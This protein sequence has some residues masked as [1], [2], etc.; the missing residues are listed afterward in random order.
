[1]YELFIQ[2]TLPYSIYQ[3]FHFIRLKIIRKTKSKMNIQSKHKHFMQKNDNFS[4]FILFIDSILYFRLW[5]SL[6][7][8]NISKSRVIDNTNMH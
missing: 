8:E 7:L 3:I 2:I 1:M 6:K 5:N 4:Y